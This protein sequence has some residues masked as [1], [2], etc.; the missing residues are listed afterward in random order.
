M[1]ITYQP[2]VGEANSNVISKFKFILQKTLT[3]TLDSE[4]LSLG[5]VS[6]TLISGQKPLFTPRTESQINQQHPL[7]ISSKNAQKEGKKGEGK[8]GMSLRYVL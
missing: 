1:S 5:Q 6:K 4:G 8:E 3:L 7:I 2:N